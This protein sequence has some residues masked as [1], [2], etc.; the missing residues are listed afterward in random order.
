MV[1]NTLAMCEGLL[2]AQAGGVN[3][4]EAVEVVGAGAAG[5]W[6]CGTIAARRFAPGLA[7][8]FTVDLQQKDIRL[9]LEAADQLGVPLPGMALIFQLYRTLQARGLG[10]EG[11]H[12]LI[13]ALENL[14]GF[15]IEPPADDH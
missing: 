9:V 14:A 13:K 15:E 7:A 10:S 1:G 11:N 2:F 8:R 12:G 3:L 5:S 4:V 6:M